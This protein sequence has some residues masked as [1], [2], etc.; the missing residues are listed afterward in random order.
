M[1]FLIRYKGHFFLIRMRGGRV[2]LIVYYAALCSEKARARN[3]RAINL[4][5][6]YV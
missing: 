4:R 6:T 1:W 2:V 5:L 3:I